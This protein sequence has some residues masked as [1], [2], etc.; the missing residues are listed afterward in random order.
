MRDDVL[1]TY[2]PIALDAVQSAMPLL[3]DWHVRVQRGASREELGQETK[4]THFA[5]LG[6]QDCVTSADLESQ[7]AILTVLRERTPNIPVVAEESASP[8]KEAAAAS[9]SLRWVVDPLNGT[10]PFVLGSADFSIT[11]ALQTYDGHKWKTEL[12]IVAS[13]VRGQIFIADAN[14]ARILEG[15]RQKILKANGRDPV[16]VAFTKESSL[17]QVLSDKLIEVAIFNKDNPDLMGAR[18]RF[19]TSLQNKNHVTHTFSTALMLAKLADGWGDAVV[20]AGKGPFENP[21][22][23]DAAMHIAEKS[24]LVCCDEYLGDEREPVKIFARSHALAR[25]LMDPLEKS[26]FATRQAGVGRGG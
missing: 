2:K 14:S 15:D 21:W 6:Y 1:Q 9:G 3:R 23:L 13:P 10:H 7:Q 26:Y 16:V 5:H 22:D 25:A 11:L 8:G 18:A 17:D 4:T 20:I 24:G 19:I 12:G